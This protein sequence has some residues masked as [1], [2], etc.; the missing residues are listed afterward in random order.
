MLLDL[1]QGEPFSFWHKKIAE[2][3]AGGAYCGIDRE[4]RGGAQGRNKARK[5]Q[6]GDDLA[7][8]IRDD[9]Q[10]HGNTADTLRVDFRH[11]QTADWAE[12]ERECRHVDE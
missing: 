7:Q 1:L 12:A 3:K 9:D 4:C 8:P 2:K 5:A 11:D 10:A 6:R